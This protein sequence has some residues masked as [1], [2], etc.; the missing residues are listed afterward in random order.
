V[1]LAGEKMRAGEKEKTR[2]LAEERISVLF[3]EAASAKNR[4]L[5]DKYVQ[6]ARRISMKTKAKL[7]REFKRRICKQ[8]H[9]YLIPGENCRIRLSRGKLVYYCLNCRHFMRFPYK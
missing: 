4:N 8:C 5:S 2:Q 9:S 7:P 6:L 1:L 3:R